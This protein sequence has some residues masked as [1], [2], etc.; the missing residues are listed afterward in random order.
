[1]ILVSTVGG[2][3]PGISD[4]T[5][6][7]LAES[8]I[9]MARETAAL[10]PRSRVKEVATGHMFNETRPEVIVDAVHTVLEM[11]AAK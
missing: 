9:V 7:K 1:M 4:E 5:A 3:P 11:H 8:R 2:K 10:S 6:A